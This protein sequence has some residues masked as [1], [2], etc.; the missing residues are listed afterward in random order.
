MSQLS[1]ND[2]RALEA[3]ATTAAVY[4]DACDGGAKFVRLDA[5]Y[6]QACGNLLLRIFSLTNARAAFPNLLERSAA[7]RDVA[8]SIEIGQRIERSRL[9]YYPDLTILLNRVAV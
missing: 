7:A 3:T 4:L 8:E 6:Y 9:A 2:L 5:D 1:Q